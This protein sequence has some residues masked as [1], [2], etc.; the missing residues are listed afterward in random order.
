MHVCLQEGGGGVVRW[1]QRCLLL[2]HLV[3][4]KPQALDGFMFTI[5]GT[6]KVEF[7]SDNSQNYVGYTKVS[8]IRVDVMFAS[9]QTFSYMKLIAQ[10]KCQVIYVGNYC[11]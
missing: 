11:L 2:N 10:T 5:N 8:S 9:C 1:L 7:V 4:I 3:I 6:G